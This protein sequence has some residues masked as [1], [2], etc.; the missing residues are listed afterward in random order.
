LRFLL[1]HAAVKSLIDIAHGAAFTSDNICSGKITKV[2]KVPGEH[3]R[4]LAD[5]FE[6]AA[7]Q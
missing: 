6:S 4:L 5:D 1:P 2:Q 7:A 3:G